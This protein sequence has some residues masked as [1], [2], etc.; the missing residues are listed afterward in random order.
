MHHGFVRIGPV[1]I[2]NGQ[3]PEVLKPGE[4]ALDNPSFWHRD[5]SVRP[6]VRPEYDIQVAIP[7]CRST[8]MATGRGNP[9]PSIVESVTYPHWSSI[10]A[11][12]CTAGIHRFR[13]LRSACPFRPELAIAFCSF[14]VHPS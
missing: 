4:G 10:H 2:V 13:L 6:F 12:C 7:S 8:S 11:A 5:K 14:T 3:P 1:F 9:F